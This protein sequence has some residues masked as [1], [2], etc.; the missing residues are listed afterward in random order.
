[1]IPA[2]LIGG[3]G[4]GLLPGAQ[5]TRL[6]ILRRGCQEASS[7]GHGSSLAAAL[8]CSGGRLNA[9]AG[10]W[11]TEYMWPCERW[12]EKPKCLL[13]L[14]DISEHPVLQWQY[15]TEVLRVL[16]LLLIDHFIIWM[17]LKS[18][19]LGKNRRGSVFLDLLLSFCWR[20]LVSIIF[21]DCCLMSYLWTQTAV[22]HLSQNHRTTWIRR[23]LR[24]QPA[25]G[26]VANH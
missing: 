20:V 15:H 1:M 8:G 16:F 6:A 3:I 7:E 11:E 13:K 9:A 14:L 5:G 2:G 19:A 26:R 22:L 12:S 25:S 18:L 4:P 10:P 24:D 21:S 17:A 23:D